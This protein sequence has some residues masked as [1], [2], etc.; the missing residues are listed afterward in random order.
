MNKIFIYHIID[1]CEEIDIPT[2]KQKLRRAESRPLK[3]RY[4]APVYLNFTVPPL[5]L[6]GRKFILRP[7]N[8]IVR[9]IF[10]FYSLGLVTIRYEIPI[11]SNDY[12]VCFQLARRIINHPFLFKKTKTLLKDIKIM[13]ESELGIKTRKELIEDYSILWINGRFD[14]RKKDFLEQTAQFLR[15]ESL[16]LSQSE[17]KE[18]LKYQFSYTKEDL[19]IIDWDRAVTIDI[20]PQ[21]DVWDILEYVNLQLLELRYYE[22]KL[23]SSLTQFYNLLNRSYLQNLIGFYRMPRILQK[24]SNIYIEFS[25][26]EKKLNSFLRLTGDEYLS[27]VYSAAARRL[28]VYSFQRF[29]KER[30]NATKTLYDTLYSQTSA[31][32]MEILEILVLSLLTLWFI[33]EFFTTFRR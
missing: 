12:S 26:E 14:P 16:P 29:L 15:D 18:A 27:R 3:K 5:E 31:I 24:L 30:L 8:I 21:E 9:T 1:I 22:N 33:V 6:P 4:F 10:K 28:N 2:L 7:E 32:R 20:S 13:I 11:E 25:E 17:Q 23:E 19:T